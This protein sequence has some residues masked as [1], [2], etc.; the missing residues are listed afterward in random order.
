MTL[1]V[2]PQ[3]LP[4]AKVV[5]EDDSC[6]LI[7][8]EYSV[9]VNDWA[10][11]I[12]EQFDGKKDID[13]IAREL[14]RLYPKSDIGSLREKVMSCAVEVWKSG[15]FLE[16]NDDAVMAIRAY[17][18]KGFAYIPKFCVMPKLDLVY[19]SPVFKQSVLG[20]STTA[21][22][23]FGDSGMSIAQY[24]DE[25][26]V[27]RLLI[28]NITACPQTYY[29]A[30]MYGQA[31]TTD[32]LASIRGAIEDFARERRQ[33]DIGSKPLSLLVQYKGQPLSRVFD[34][35]EEA[36]SLDRE[37]GGERLYVTRVEF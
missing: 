3:L 15:V 7:A 19:L 29:L 30:A 23:N 4:H 25:N 24:D 11:Q 14:H 32:D 10:G 31:F 34:S 33:Y 2:N 35:E 27:N 6:T 17:G 1:S 13:A 22:I 36:Y 12:I 26:S 16:H 20:K 28:L 37:F 9:P 8:S 21:T 5:R 18:E